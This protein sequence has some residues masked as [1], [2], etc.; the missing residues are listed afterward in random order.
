MYLN[1]LIYDRFVRPKFTVELYIKKIVERKFDFEGKNVLDFGCGSGSNSFLFSPNNY[2]GL[3]V[4]KNR[5]DFAIKKFADYKFQVIKNSNLPSPD[6]FFDF[7]C[8]FATIHHIP[9]SDFQKYIEEF[10]RILKPNEQIIIIEPYINEKNKFSN[11]FMT[12]FDDGK[13]IRSEEEYLDFFKKD[14]AIT[15]H[16]KFRKFFFYNEIFFS[17]KIKK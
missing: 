1:P 2:L 6:N 15:V 13:Y 12:T 4:D 3:D 7:I 11:W 14:I 17:A 16:K 5:V 8:I 10:K 9:S